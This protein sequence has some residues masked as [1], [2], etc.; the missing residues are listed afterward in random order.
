MN[1]E[2]LVIVALIV[3]FPALIVIGVLSDQYTCKVK[4]EAMGMGHSWGLIQGCMVTTKDGRTVPLE[5]IREID[6]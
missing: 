3:G 5:A 4:A 1:F 6:P 2:K